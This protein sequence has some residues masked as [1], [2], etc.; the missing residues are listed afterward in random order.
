MGSCPGR[1]FGFLDCNISAVETIFSLVEVRGLKACCTLLLPH[2]YLDDEEDQST[3]D[4]ARPEEAELLRYV[5][6]IA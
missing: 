2:A 3:Y 5:Q 6:H 4:D 1:I